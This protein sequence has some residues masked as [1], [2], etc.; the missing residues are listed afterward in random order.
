M[1]RTHPSQRPALP[2][3]G[4]RATAA[5]KKASSCVSPD[6]KLLEA[7]RQ[8]KQ[9]DA[10]QHRHGTCCQHDRLLQGG[11]C[12]RTAAAAAVARQSRADPALVL[13]RR[14]RH[15]HAACCC[16]HALPLAPCCCTCLERVLVLDRQRCRHEAQPCCNHHLGLQPERLVVVQ[17]QVKRLLNQL[18]MLLVLLAA[19]AQGH[20]L[21]LLLLQRCSPHGPLPELAGEHWQR[22]RHAPCRGQLPRA[23][24]T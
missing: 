22:R 10:P 15:S 3:C 8:H 16:L 18:H 7:A 19:A 20:L 11:A 24:C 14:L 23:S 13:P 1:G 2:L 9:K 6:G 17:I 5:A 12:S 21:L 4:T